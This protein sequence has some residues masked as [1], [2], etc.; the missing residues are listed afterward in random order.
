[1]KKAGLLVY[2]MLCMILLS[3]GNQGKEYKIGVSQCGG[4]RWRDK[5]NSEMQAA[6]HLYEYD[7]KV[8]II[9][10]QDDSQRQIRQID[11]LSDAGIDLLVVAPN[12]SAPLAEAIARTRQK[13]IPVVFFDRKA[14]TNDYSAFIGGDNT[15]AGRTVASY[16]LQLTSEITDRHPVI[17]EITGTM[18]T[19]PAQERHRGFSEVL[20]QHPDIDYHSFDG[21]WSADSAYT[22]TK[23][24]MASSGPVDIIFCHSDF[25][26]VGIHQAAQEAQQEAHVKI[27][28][29]DGMPDEGIAYVQQGL[30]AGTCIY[31][32][33][34][35][36]IVRLALDILTGQPFER[37]INLQGMMVTPENADLIGL[38]TNELMRQNADLITIQDKL[39]HYLGLTNLLNKMLAIGA[40]TILLLIVGILL[41]WQAVR[42][43]RRATRQMKRLNEE[44]TLF[45]NNASH[46]LRTPLTL[47]AGPV[48][49]LLAN[50]RLDTKQQHLMDII[51]RNVE[52]LETLISS[53]LNFRSEMSSRM[54][55]EN[56]S[57]AVHQQQAEEMVR[58]SRLEMIKHED[59]EELPSILIVDDNK[60]MLTYLRTLLADKFYVLEAANGQSGLKLAF[61]IV[62]DIVVSDVMMPV[63]DGLQFCKKLKENA[64]TSHIPVILLTARSTEQQQMEGYEHGADAYLTKP[65]NADVLISRIYNLVKSRQQLRVLFDNKSE[66]AT[67]EQPQ[68]NSQDKLFAETLKKVILK[69]MTNPSL[70]MDELGEELGISRV[71]LYRKVKALTGLSPVELLRQMRLQR[72]YGLL[73]T[74]TK[75]VN[76]IAYEVGFGTP[77]YFSKCFKEQFGKY[78]MDVRQN[79]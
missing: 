53:V 70:K 9:S 67:P 72:A 68:F 39:E 28:G 10:A 33:Q 55:D 34:G 57:A 14:D 25:M 61:D 36:R 79:I 51:S 43:S 50:G 45:Y 71:Q 74:S 63:M 30:M 29:I 19:S 78:P 65:F 31:P 20:S 44:Q 49:E 6:Q 23:N 64:V 60:D 4:G 58:K 62:P 13:G 32:T 24:F 37:D 17:V 75:T 22:I 8:E 46:Q 41:T 54:S 73:T 56:V 5:V 35:E 1:M 26:S 76:E 48:K 11:S 3:C 21:K 2:A 77:G 15:E 27:L 47:I 12:E 40:F 66:A 69:N 38:N 16:A 52:K 18:Q 7:A 42:K 59:T